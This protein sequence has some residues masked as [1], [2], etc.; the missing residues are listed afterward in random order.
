MEFS[1]SPYDYGLLGFMLGVFLILMKLLIERLSGV[2][3]H[4]VT[5]D[6]ADSKEA[7]ELQTVSQQ[8]IGGMVIT[9]QTLVVEQTAALRRIADQQQVG[10][11]TTQAKVDGVKDLVVTGFDGVHKALGERDGVLSEIKSNAIASS[12]AL[13]RLDQFLDNLAP[14][15]SGIKPVIDNIVTQNQSIL[16]R[17]QILEKET[18][19]E[20]SEVSAVAIAAA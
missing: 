2:I 7:N 10:H 6:R 14:S 20:T 5:N 15:L 3:S 12:Q 4:L 11:S 8:T 9:F 17:I 16:D 1:L 13:S 19:S 18:P